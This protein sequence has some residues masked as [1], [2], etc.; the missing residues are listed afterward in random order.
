MWTVNKHNISETCDP[1]SHFR[2]VSNQLGEFDGDIYL[3]F[4][5]KGPLNMQMRL[6]NDVCTGLH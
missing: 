4:I 6:F 1:K 5:Q 3:L 2:N